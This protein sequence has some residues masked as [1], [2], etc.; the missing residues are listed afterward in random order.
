M[1][2]E[3]NPEKLTWLTPWIFDPRFVFNLQLKRFVAFIIK[4]Y[5]IDMLLRLSNLKLYGRA[6]THPR[7]SRPI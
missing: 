7:K 4:I 1:V 5:I 2:L 3:E 6:Y